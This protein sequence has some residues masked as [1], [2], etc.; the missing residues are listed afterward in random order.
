MCPNIP[1]KV[2]LNL[3]RK[4]S[5]ESTD[6][7]EKDHT[8]KYSR[9]TSKLINFESE[10]LETRSRRGSEC[11][12]NDHT[13]SKVVSQVLV[14]EVMEKVFQNISKLEEAKN[15]NNQ[16]DSLKVG[17]PRRTGSSISVKFGN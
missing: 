17:R 1:D 2:S 7:D 5:Y 8:M 3:D 14:N 13:L 12:Y 10:P 6:A 4:V 15:I 16:L 9:V 11:S